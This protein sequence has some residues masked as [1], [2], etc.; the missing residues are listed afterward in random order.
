M[1]VFGTQKK[2]SFPLNRDVPSIEVTN[3]NVTRY[4]KSSIKPPPRGGLFFSSTFE[5]GGLNREGGLFNS[6]PVVKL[7][8]YETE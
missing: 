2:Y 5:G 4:R 6:S 3:K 8:W 1:P 7:L